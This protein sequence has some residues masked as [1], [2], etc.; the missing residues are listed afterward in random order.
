[1]EQMKKRYV[2]YALR[3][4]FYQNKLRGVS[5]DNWQD[6]PFTLKH[7]LRDADPYSLLGV[8]LKEIAT[9]HETSGTTGR[10]TSSW[11]SHADVEH[12]ARLVSQSDLALQPEDVILNRYTFTVA[13]GSFIILWAAQQSKA[14]HICVAKSAISTPLRAIDIIDRTNPTIIA[15]LPNQM[16]L[17]AGVYNRLGKPLSIQSLRSVLIAGELASPARQRWIEKLWGVPV[18]GLFGSTETGGLFMTCKNGHYHIDNERVYVEIVDDDGKPKESG[19]GNLV[20][21]TIREGTPVLRYKN[22][23]LAEIR[24]A[25]HCGCGNPAPVLIHYGRNEDAVS[26]SGRKFTTYDMQEIVYSLP[27]VPLMWRLH[28]KSDQLEFEYQPFDT[29]GNPGNKTELERIL[30]EQFGMPVKSYISEI[31]PESEMMK[32]GEA[33]KFQ[34]VVAV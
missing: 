13:V 34:H 3:S 12:E 8:P 19:A 30:S 20:V 5:L 18:Y 10:P 31:V 9:Y 26:I 33:Y 24:P 32:Q 17:I 29:N 28:V 22:N 25:D 27:E 11:F 6:V 21:S 2:E 7:E 16:E 23:D 14:S 4:D 1:M 15:D